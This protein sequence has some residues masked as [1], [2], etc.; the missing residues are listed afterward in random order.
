[1]PA[2][3]MEDEWAVSIVDQCRAAGVACFV[4]QVTVNG[5]VQHDLDKFPTKLQIREFPKV[6]RLSTPC[7]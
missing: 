1:M 6:E 4:K 5:R 2:G 3:P 7:P